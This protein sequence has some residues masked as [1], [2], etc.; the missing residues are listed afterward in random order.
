[1]GVLTQK[2][3]RLVFVCVYAHLRMH[4]R[5]CVCACV[6]A[7]VCVDVRVCVCVHDF[8][9]YLGADPSRLNLECR[10]GNSVILTKITLCSDFFKLE[11]K[12]LKT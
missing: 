8:A 4:A 7:C 10:I 9:D 1:M 6:R 12:T 3:R 11:A 2:L 5:V